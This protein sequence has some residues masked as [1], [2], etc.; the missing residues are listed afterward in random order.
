MKVGVISIYWPP[1]FGGAE[2]YVHSMVDSLV[3]KGVD[4]WGITATPAR[5]DRDSGIEFVHRIGVET[6]CWDKKGCERWFEQVV[7]HVNDE[8]YTHVL[9]NSPLTRTYYL[10][11]EKLFRGLRSSNHALK[12][13]VVHH[14]LGLRSRG[15]L[16]RFKFERGDWES[17]A[18]YFEEELRL[19]HDSKSALF[20]KQDGYMAFDSPL[21]FDPDFVVGN[22]EWSNRFINP[23]KSTPHY[24]LHPIIE[25]LDGPKS[26]KLKRVNITFLN[27]LFHKGRSYMADF[28]ND[29]SHEWTFRVLLGSYG[30]QKQEFIRM[31]KDS[32][33]VRDGRVDIVDYVE[34]I[35]DA[36]DATDLFL[37]P[38][39]YEGYGMAAVEPMFRGVPVIVQDYPAIIEA[40][41]DAAIVMPYEI[42]SLSW[43]ETVED[44]LEYGVDMELFKEKGLERSVFLLK[45]QEDEVD[46]LI[47]FLGGLE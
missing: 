45:R 27:P 10:F 37:F 30:G 9:I 20:T 41:G 5:E 13:G 32:W 3:N 15:I 21:F 22:T 34:D 16:E 29:Y 38:S 7:A 6:H 28:I 11:C 39:R 42:G 36:Y 31:I 12:I 1:H 23:M 24:V 40:V 18:Q 47:A 44:L 33:A 8:S 17:A 43:I 4:A 19:F 26:D 25:P 46:G 14:D 2:K 35:I